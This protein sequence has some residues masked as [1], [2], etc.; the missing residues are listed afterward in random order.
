MLLTSKQ[1]AKFGENLTSHAGLLRESRKLILFT[2]VYFIL[3][4]L[5]SA[6]FLEAFALHEFYVLCPVSLLDLQV[7]TTLFYQAL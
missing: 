1:Q 7:N 6:V 2:Y 4:C 5:Y 3:F